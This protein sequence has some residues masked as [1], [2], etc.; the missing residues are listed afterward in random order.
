MILPLVVTVVVMRLRH[1]RLLLT[2]AGRLTT[3]VVITETILTV[4]IDVRW[5]VR[6]FGLRRSAGV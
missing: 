4:V 6:G 3:V 1:L 2:T 5:S